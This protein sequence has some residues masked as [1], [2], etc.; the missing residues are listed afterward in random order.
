MLFVPVYLFIYSF[1]YLFIFF[2]FNFFNQIM[3][4]NSRSDEMA[5]RGFYY[6]KE[7]TLS[8]LANLKIGN[9][10]KQKDGLYIEM[11][12]SCLYDDIKH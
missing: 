12:Y 3:V 11:G 2:F 7:E 8:P 9:T 5:T 1:I 10:Y 6:H 4:Q